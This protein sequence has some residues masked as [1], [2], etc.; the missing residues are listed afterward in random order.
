MSY[1]TINL[2]VTKAV[3]HLTLVR[4]EELNTLTQ[5]FWREFPRAI[6][7]IDANPQ[8]RVLVISST[9]RH[10]TAGMD[11]SLLSGIAPDP[12]GEAGRQR[13]RLRR[14]VLELQSVF[15]ALENLRIPVIAAIQGGCIG[16][17]VDLVTACDMRYCTEDAFF[18]VM[19][20]NI[21]MAADLGT[22][23]RLPRLVPDGLARELA[24]TGRR[25][26]AAQARDAGLVNKVYGDQEAM[27]EGVLSLA[28]E[29]AAKSPLAITGSKE[30]LN[31]AT[32][33]SVA[34]SLTY[35]ATWQ[36]GMLLGE[37]IMKAV[38]AHMGKTQ[39]EFADL[40]EA[41]PLTEVSALTED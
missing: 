1:R 37:D 9:G 31:Y 12:K 29:I 30:M 23:Q 3:A 21:G 18:S 14:Q 25:L 39:A 22:L 8:V 13:E 11:F 28:G 20:I 7:E 40:Y 32:D 36:S 10:F 26:S 17:G 5:D 19:E 6:A 34:D 2:E 41:Q 38:T 33:H 16:G 15:T 27:L 35:M 24:Y 4:G